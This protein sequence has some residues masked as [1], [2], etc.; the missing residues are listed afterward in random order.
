MQASNQLTSI[1]FVSFFQAPAAAEIAILVFMEALQRLGFGSFLDFFI[2]F[3][4]SDFGAL[5][6]W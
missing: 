2:V 1:L 3:W 4:I 5:A 6:T